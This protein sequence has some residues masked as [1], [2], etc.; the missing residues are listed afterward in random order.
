MGNLKSRVTKL[1]GSTPDIDEIFVYGGFHPCDP[2]DAHSAY[3]DGQTIR[4]PEG[5]AFDDFRAR[6]RATAKAGQA[7]VYGGLPDDE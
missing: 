2:M 6:C 5:E 3:I 4:R 1:E 7:V